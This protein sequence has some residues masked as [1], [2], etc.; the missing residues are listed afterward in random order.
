VKE[1]GITYP[2]FDSTKIGKMTGLNSTVNNFGFIV[3]FFPP[4][5][6]TPDNLCV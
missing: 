6:L 4:G 5:D 2:L 3:Y 1:N